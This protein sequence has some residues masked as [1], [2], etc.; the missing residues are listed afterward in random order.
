MVRIPARVVLRE[1][2]GHE[3]L[4]HLRADA[5]PDAPALVARGAREFEAGPEGTTSL[6][7]DAARLHIFWKDTSRR[8]DVVEGGAGE[9][10]VEA[11]RA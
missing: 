7:L 11:A 6:F 4:T 1:P 2:L 10:S 9:R 3:T 5:A 8:V